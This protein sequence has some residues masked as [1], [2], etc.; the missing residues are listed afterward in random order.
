VTLRRQ[1]YDIRANII[2]ARDVIVALCAAINAIS[3]EPA[4]NC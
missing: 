1:E 2:Q 3:R 4:S